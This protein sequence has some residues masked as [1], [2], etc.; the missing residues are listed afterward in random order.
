[1]SILPDDHPMQTPPPAPQAVPAAERPAYMAVVE[2]QV[3]AVQR[4]LREE[5]EVRK[6]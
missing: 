3:A 5:R 2:Q 4:K 1:V 6:Q